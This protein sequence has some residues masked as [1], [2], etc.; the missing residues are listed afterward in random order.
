MFDEAVNLTE[1]TDTDT[2]Q[3]TH[4]TV[5][6]PTKSYTYGTGKEIAD[7]HICKV[8]PELV[9]CS[10]YRRA[11]GE[12]LPVLPALSHAPPKIGQHENAQRCQHRPQVEHILPQL[13]R[14]QS[15]SNISRRC[16]MHL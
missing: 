7:E 15:R 4:L 3:H 8:I 2:G 12:M 16:Q 1:R 5:A 14:P 11:V 13:R 10:P 6:A 9:R